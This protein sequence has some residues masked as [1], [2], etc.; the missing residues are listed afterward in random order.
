MPESPLAGTISDKPEYRGRFAP[1]PTGPLHIGSLV[2]AVASYLDARAAGGQWLV[3]IENLD[4][5]RELPG[6]DRLILDSL[7]CHGLEWNGQ[8]RYQGAN[9]ARYRDAVEQ[10]IEAGDAYVCGCSRQQVRARGRIGPIGPVY[11]GTCRSRQ[12]TD[13][14]GSTAVRLRATPGT[15]SFRDRLQ[16]PVACRVG[17]LIGD[18]VIRRR[19]GLL[20]YVLASTLDDHLQGITD[21]VRGADLLDYTPAQICLQ[22]RLGLSVPRYMH[23]PVAS[24]ECG[25]KFSKQTGALPIDDSRAAE[26]LFWCLC[27]LRQNPEPALARATSEEIRCWAIRHWNPEPLSGLRERRLRAAELP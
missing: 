9:L 6:S 23:V 4:P 24:N 17:E 25:E 8:V 18:V 26:N 2:A 5:P 21:V 12:L 27:F 13:R 1:S 7:E 22:R 19:D 11:P 3:R 15:T 16:G 20:A 14:P 10:L